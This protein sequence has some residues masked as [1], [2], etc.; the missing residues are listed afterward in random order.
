MGR[1]EDEVFILSPMTPGDTL[2]GPGITR[3][4]IQDDDG[5]D[6]L[7]LFDLSQGTP[8]YLVSASTVTSIQELTA[9]REFAVAPNPF[10]DQARVTWPNPDNESFRVQLLDLT[11]QVLRIY[12]TVQGESLL[13]EKEDLA[14]GIYFLRFTHEAGNVETVKLLLRE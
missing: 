14:P 11:G 7:R 6:V 3:E 10:Y 2:P 1:F 12:P 5:N 13:V 4:I 9:S 8:R